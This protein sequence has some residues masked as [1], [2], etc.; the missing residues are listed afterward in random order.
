MIKDI[1]IKKTTIGDIVANNFSTSKV[2]S[3]YGIDFCCNG[4]DTFETAS[5]KAKVDPSVVL[6]A[7]VKQEEAPEKGG[8]IP[9]NLWPKDLL[10]DYVLKI[11][12][13]GI[14]ENGPEIS[15]LFKKVIN[16]HSAN[17]PELF[18]I[19][20]LFLDSLA[21]LESHLLKE[22]HMLYPHLYKLFEAIRNNEPIEKFHGGSVSNPIRVMMIE[23]DAEGSRYREIR[24]LSNNLTPPDDACNS[25]KMLYLMLA[26][27]EKDLHEHIHLENNIIFPWAIEME[28]K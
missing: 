26:E 11:H 24:E 13:R 20:E 9:F 28:S 3:L 16:A 21:A 14:R 4:G 1:N 17:H 8:E 2:F 7:L 19:Q 18:E 6:E 22:E 10:I 15:G 5:K 27:F 25:Y 23:H 12:H